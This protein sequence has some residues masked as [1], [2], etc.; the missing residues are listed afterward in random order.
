MGEYVLLVPGDY[1][2]LQLYLA[3]ARFSSSCLVKLILSAGDERMV[4]ARDLKETRVR[5]SGFLWVRPE[6]S[7]GSGVGREMGL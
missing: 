6:W 5:A 7:R 4:V 2:D 1:S 3:G